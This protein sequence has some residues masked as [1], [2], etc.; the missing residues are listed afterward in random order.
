MMTDPIADMLT[1]IR[2]GARIELP[3]VDMP[4]TKMKRHVAQVL[5]DEGFIIDYQVGMMATLSAILVW[6]ASYDRNFLLAPGPLK[7]LLTWTGTRSYALYLWHIPAFFATREIWFRLAPDGTVFDASWTIT[8]IATAGVLLPA[9][10]ELNYRLIEMPLRQRGA[11]AASGW[12][13]RHIRQTPA[14]ST[15]A[16]AV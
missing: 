5:K 9:I 14:T 15:V 12:Y 10:A 3:A 1:R 8:F 16:S 6:I 11:A 2:N 13:Q 7:S 4:S